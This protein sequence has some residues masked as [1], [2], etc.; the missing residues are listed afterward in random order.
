[1]WSLYNLIDQ[2]L[3]PLGYLTRDAGSLRRFEPTVP[4]AAE[5]CR[6]TA[7]EA[8]APRLGFVG[9]WS[10]GLYILKLG[11]DSIPLNPKP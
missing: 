8:V 6:C 10:G 2:L 1:M 11:S 4:A 3:I 5:G 7:A 9:S